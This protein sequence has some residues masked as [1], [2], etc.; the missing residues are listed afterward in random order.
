MAWDEQRRMREPHTDDTAQIT[1]VQAAPASDGPPA[2][3][4]PRAESGFEQWGRRFGWMVAVGLSVLAILMA[5]LSLADSGGGHGG[6]RRGGAG[7]GGQ[8]FGSGGF[9]Y[10]GY[11]YGGQSG[12]SGSGSQTPTSTGGSGQFPAPQGAPSQ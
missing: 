7:F 1:G 10:R 3:A 11:G 6:F 2:S 4:S 12:P 9:G 8:G 5:G